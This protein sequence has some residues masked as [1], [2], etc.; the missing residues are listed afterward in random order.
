MLFYSTWALRVLCTTCLIHLSHTLIQAHYFHT[1]SPSSIHTHIQTLMDALGSNLM[2]S[3]LLEDTL[4]WRLEQQP[5]TEPSSSAIFEFSGLFSC[6]IQYALE[7]Y[8]SLTIWQIQK[9]VIFSSRPLKKKRKQKTAD[10]WKDSPA[11]VCTRYEVM[12]IQNKCGEETIW[13][14]FHGNNGKMNDWSLL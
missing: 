7:W 12:N 8:L 4:T 6:S 13:L 9:N 10:S 2:F 3:I 1:C 14:S 5:G 11:F